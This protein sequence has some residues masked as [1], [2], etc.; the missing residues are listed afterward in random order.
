M[1]VLIY[2]GI[3]AVGVLLVAVLTAADFFTQSVP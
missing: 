2:V 1:N 3:A